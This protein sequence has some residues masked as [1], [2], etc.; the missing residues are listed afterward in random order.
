MSEPLSRERTPIRSRH[1]RQTTGS[2]ITWLPPEQVP[3]GVLSAEVERE[4][5][6]KLRALREWVARSR[7]SARS[8]V[9]YR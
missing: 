4:L 7:V 9:I 3:G 6:E 5:Q 1:Q 8:Y 2:G